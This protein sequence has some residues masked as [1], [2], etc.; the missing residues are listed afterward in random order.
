LVTPSKHT[1]KPIE[2]VDEIDWDKVDTDE[3]EHQAILSTPGSSQK[4]SG[5]GI[6]SQDTPARA[7][8]R[9]AVEE[10][11]SKR[12]ITETP[13]RERLRAA[14]EEGASKRKREDED[15]TPK[16]ARLDSEVR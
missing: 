14:L 7:R 16:R 11:A 15:E 5:S 2:V 9:A 4:A 10:G 13:S 3:L 12:T 6:G 8:L 1:S